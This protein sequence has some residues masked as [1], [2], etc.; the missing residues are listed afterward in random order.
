ML[1]T[2]RRRAIRCAAFLPPARSLT[3]PSQDP[4]GTWSAQEALE[5]AAYDEIRQRLP[6]LRARDR[7]RDLGDVFAPGEPRF[8]DPVHFG[9]QG[10]AVIADAMLPV[11]LDALGDDLRPPGTNRCRT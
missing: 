6:A 2:C 1:A 10:Q 9:D 11:V 3:R 7:V 5:R 8:L 4:T